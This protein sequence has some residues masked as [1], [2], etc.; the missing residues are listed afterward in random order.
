[1]HHG[2]SSITSILLIRREKLDYPG[3]FNVPAFPAG[4]RIATSRV[5]GIGILSVC[6]LIIFACGMILWASSARTVD[7]FLISINPITGNWEIVGH[8]HGQKELSINQLAQMSTINRFVQ[9]WF[10]ISPDES[11]NDARWS[12]CSDEECLDSNNVM[13]G[14]NECSLYCMSD[15]KLFANFSE[16][17]VPDYSERARRG[18]YWFVK[19]DTIRITPPDK[20]SDQGGTW[21]VTA[22]IMSNSGD[23]QILAYANV[24]KSAK[25]TPA[26][27]GVYPLNYVQTMGYKVIKFNSYRIN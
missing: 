26:P 4:L 8:T 13:Y 19:P 5:M 10:Y 21:R 24:A 7:P 11:A 15:E 27:D 25:S 23:F 3:G 17:T 1:M 18:V 12:P 16:N 9:D 2:L 6:V 14:G 20:I 22:T